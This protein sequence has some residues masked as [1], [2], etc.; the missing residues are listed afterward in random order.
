[1]TRVMQEVGYDAEM[2]LFIDSRG[3][4]MDAGGEI[5]GA[6]RLKEN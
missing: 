4:L 2:K 6:G 5:M 3:M 1:M